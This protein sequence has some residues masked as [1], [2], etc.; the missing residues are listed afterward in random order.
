M[1]V[2]TTA[3]TSDDLTDSGVWTEGGSAF[4]NVVADQHGGN[5]IDFDG[6]NDDVDTG[7]QVLTSGT[8]GSFV[9]WVKTTTTATDSLFQERDTTGTGEGWY[10]RTI[11]GALQVSATSAAAGARSSQTSTLINDGAYHRIMGVVR[12][13]TVLDVYI[14]GVEATY[15]NHSYKVNGGFTGFVSN[16]SKSLRVGDNSNNSLPYTGIASRPS[17]WTEALSAA[18]VLE[19]YDAEVALLGSPDTDIGGLGRPS[20]RNSMV[21]QNKWMRGPLRYRR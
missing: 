19:E 4:S 12:S 13:T 17:V 16:V 7:A 11:G 3:F 10:I 5:A 8:T 6:V 14:D 9:I 2:P 20:F 1:T 21:R 18:Q 15:S